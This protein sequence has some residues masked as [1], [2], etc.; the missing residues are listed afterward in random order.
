MAPKEGLAVAREEWMRSD[1]SARVPAGIDTSVAHIARVYDYWLGGKDNF[2][3]DREAGD[4][5]AEADPD[6]FRSVRANRAFIAR[7]VSYLVADQ[8][9]R[10]F[11][12]IGTGLPSANNTHEV[13]QAAA[14]DA[15]IVYVDNDPIVLAHARALLTSTRQG[16]TDY[17]DADLRDTG[18]ILADAAATLDFSKPVAVML[19]AVL[20]CVPEDDEPYQVV[21]RL[22]DAV[23]PGSFLTLAHV[24]SDITADAMADMAGRLN[25]LMKQK[26]TYRDHAEV[27]RF[28]DG[29]EMVE[30]G[31]VP[32]SQWRPESETEAA[33]PA[34]LWGGVAR[35]VA[36]M[37]SES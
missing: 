17:I 31:L 32:V 3:A 18:K 12:D 2:A 19:V 34:K 7:T 23:P 9:I 35:K 25:R 16:A 14:P 20:H 26:V 24:A 30:P 29:L 37:R 28:F 6:V 10:Q 36:G 1:P 22:M 11:M 8:G 27:G 15:R 4:Q 33:S 13:A 21:G 5:A